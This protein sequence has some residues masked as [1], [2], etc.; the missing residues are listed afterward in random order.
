MAAPVVEFQTDG[1]THRFRA[2]V[3]DNGRSRLLH[4]VDALRAVAQSRPNSL[5]PYKSD[6]MCPAKRKLPEFDV[7]SLKPAFDRVWMDTL[8]NNLQ[9]MIARRS[10]EEGVKRED[11]WRDETGWFETPTRLPD[12]RRGETESGRT[13]EDEPVVPMSS[14][15]GPVVYD[16]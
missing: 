2:T 11:E 12:E 9:T 15:I 1:S 4:G 16:H 8:M 14:D 7:P 5:C 10:E 3:R 13:T 6:S